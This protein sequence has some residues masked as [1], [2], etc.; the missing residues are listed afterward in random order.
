LSVEA[1]QLRLICDVLTAVAAG[2]VGAVGG[3][4]SWPE[5]PI[6]VFMSL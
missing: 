3:C 1:L 6:C 5:F 2:L 4:V